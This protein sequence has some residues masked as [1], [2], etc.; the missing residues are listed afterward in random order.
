MLPKHDLQFLAEASGLACTTI[1]G[2]VD[3][4]DKAA[5]SGSGG[6]NARQR[7]CIPRVQIQSQVPQSPQTATIAYRNCLNIQTKLKCS[8]H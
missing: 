7:Q 6:H 4:H 1:S 8:G 2:H 3:L 5:I